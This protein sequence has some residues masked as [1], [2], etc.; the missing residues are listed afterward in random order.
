MSEPYKMLYKVYKKDKAS[1]ERMKLVEEMWKEVPNTHCTKFDELPDEIK[2][3]N[4][5]EVRD[6]EKEESIRSIV[7]VSNE[8]LF[9]EL[10]RNLNTSIL[11]INPEL[12]KGENGVY[13]LTINFRL[14]DE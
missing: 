6:K 4:W 14:Q 7:K 11:A 8:R 9:K 2:N 1:E 5:H 10:A 12:V 3:C 13:T